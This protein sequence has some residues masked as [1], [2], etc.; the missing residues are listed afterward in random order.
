MR[1]KLIIYKIV[2][3]LIV[4]M[5]KKKIFSKICTIKSKNKENLICKILKTKK[6]MK[7]K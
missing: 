2:I 5:I 6:H 7:M 3:K 4:K 1:A